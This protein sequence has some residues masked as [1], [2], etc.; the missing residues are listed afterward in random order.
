MAKKIPKA[1]V[2]YGHNPKTGQVKTTKPAKGILGKLVDKAL[3]S[4]G[5]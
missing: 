4:Q 2:R 5:R 1:T 3:K